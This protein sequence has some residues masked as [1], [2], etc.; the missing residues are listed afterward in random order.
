M[1]A[2]VGI[3]GYPVLIR[4][5]EPHSKD[6]LTVPMVEHFNHCISWLPQ[7][8][9]RP[10]MFLDGTAQYHDYTT[11]PAMDRGATVL[12]VEDGKGVVREVPWTDPRQNLLEREF[13]VQLDKQGNAR[14]EIV[15]RPRMN[16]ALWIRDR[17]GNEPGK[18]KERL[19]DAYSRMFGKVEVEDFHFSDLQNL[20]EP[21]EMKVT[22]KVKDFVQKQGDDFVLKSSFQ[23]EELVKATSLETREFDL[24]LGPPSGKRTRI[25]YVLPEGFD[26]LPLSRPVVEDG[27]DLSFRFEWGRKDRSLLIDQ[28]VLYKSARVSAKNYP[29]FK[30][31]AE[32][33]DRA[34]KQ[35]LVV[36]PAQ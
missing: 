26:P 9:D 23:P 7:S 8:G 24:M 20:D 16:H 17:F 10:A 33:L 30:D 18:R 21:V 35:I 27:P 11:T 4:G 2:E 32:K 19:E 13:T 12:V 14:V 15:E 22:L 3:K 34:E 28:E 1:L 29:A 36:R 6:D 31:Q 25:R 5:E